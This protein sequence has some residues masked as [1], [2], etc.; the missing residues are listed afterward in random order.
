[1]PLNK[2]TNQSTSDCLVSYQGHSFGE[3]YLSAETQSVYSAA[4]AEWANILLRVKFNQNRYC[5]KDPFIYFF[6]YIRM[7]RAVLNKSWKQHL[8]KLQL[9]GH[10]P[11]ISK[12]IQDMQDYVGESKKNSQPM[13][14]YGLLHMDTP[15]SA[16]QQQLTSNMWLWCN[17]YRRW[18]CT[19][20]HEFE[21]WTVF[22]IARIPLGK[23]WIQLF[24]LQLWVNSRADW[25]L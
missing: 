11:P 10:V 12:T 1:M 20:G 6:F 2:E 9:F 7:Q 23:V 18:K 4:P 17:G 15:G 14:C 5:K 25:V 22:H 3:S 16:N 19:R 13:F 24:S 21:F 8:R